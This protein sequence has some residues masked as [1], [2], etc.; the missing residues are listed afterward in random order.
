MKMLPFAFFDENSEYIPRNYKTE[1]CVVYTSS[2]DS[3]CAKSWIAELPKYARELFDRERKKIKGESRVYSA[4]R[5]AFESK[6][7]LAIV[8]MQ[9][10]LELTNDEGRMNMPSTPSGNWGWRMSKRYNTKALRE[11]ISSLTKQTK[12]KWKTD[13]ENSVV[14]IGEFV[15]TPVS[16]KNQHRICMHKCTWAVAQT[17]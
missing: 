9:D 16:V 3:D 14:F 1:N 12:R 15:I 7:N 10:Y 11:K 13:G 6:A 5:L 4:I 8:Q 17:H 2:H